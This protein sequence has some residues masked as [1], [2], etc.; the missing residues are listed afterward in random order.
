MELQS[1]IRAQY[2]SFD[3]Q[4]HGLLL[5]VNPPEQTDN[6]M[7][8]N[9]NIVFYF[10]SILQYEIQQLVD[11]LLH[12]PFIRDGTLFKEFFQIK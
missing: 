10:S 5:V 9:E 1:S 4:G 2:Q 7:E 6:E 8:L 3:F 11:K 12:I